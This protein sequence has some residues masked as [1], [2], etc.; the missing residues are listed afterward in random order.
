M[1]NSDKIDKF[2]LMSKIILLSIILEIFWMIMLLYFILKNEYIRNK[3][4]Y[5]N[6]LLEWDFNSAFRNLL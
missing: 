6:F 3:Y 5:T 4:S 2:L 1:K